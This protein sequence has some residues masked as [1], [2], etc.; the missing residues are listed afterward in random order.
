VL[1]P[2][3]TF[4]VPTSLRLEGKTAVSISESILVTAAGC[5]V[6][7]RFEPRELIVKP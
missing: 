3:M 7:T 4:H 5:E 6:L 1:E 2:G